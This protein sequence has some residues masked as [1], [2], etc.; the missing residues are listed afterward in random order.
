MPAYFQSLEEDDSDET[1]II[2]PEL[3]GNDIS[4][5]INLDCSQSED[6]SNQDLMIETAGVLGRR[7]M[8]RE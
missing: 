8:R 7:L 2:V 1:F 4:L 6:W 5:T 3:R